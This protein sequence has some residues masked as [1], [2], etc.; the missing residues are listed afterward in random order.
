MAFFEPR[1]HS[2][3]IRAAPLPRPRF[4]HVLALT[5]SG[6]ATAPVI[7]RIGINS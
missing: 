7:I 6:S 1:F 2:R 5:S 4:E 3:T